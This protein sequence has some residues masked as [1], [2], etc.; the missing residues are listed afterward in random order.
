MLPGKHVPK[1]VFLQQLS[2][3]VMTALNYATQQGFASI[4]LPAI[5][6]GNL[7][8]PRDV[9]AE[10]MF[11]T[12]IE[13]SKADPATSVKDVRFILHDQNQPTIDVRN[14]QNFKTFL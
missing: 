2:D 12:V 8:F 6:T 1:W 13:F 9:V 11:N 4:A 10:T 5:G 7:H 3:L 14:S